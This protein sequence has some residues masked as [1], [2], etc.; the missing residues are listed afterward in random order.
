MKLEQSGSES[1][2]SDCRR[3]T[4]RSGDAAYDAI[5]EVNRAPQTAPPSS[6]DTGD[7]LVGESSKDPTDRTSAGGAEYDLAA[8]VVLNDVAADCYSYV[9]NVSRDK[10]LANGKP[11]DKTRPPLANKPKQAAV[12]P[13]GDKSEKGVVE[14]DSVLQDLYAV[15]MKTKEQQGEVTLVDN[16]LYES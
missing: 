5:T 11:Q 14:E 7:I 13:V 15:P 9:T 10:R 4:P 1:P 6:G 16:Q 3:H 8:D 2:H 12:T